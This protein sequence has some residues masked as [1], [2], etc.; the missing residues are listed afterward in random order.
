MSGNDTPTTGTDAKPPPSD[1]AGAA[2]DRIELRGLRL[3]AHVGVSEAE[4]MQAQP[5]ELDV[6]LLVD[7]RP[8]AESD[9]V[10]DTVDYG[11]AAIAIAEAVGHGQHH[12]LERVAKVAADAAFGA[13]QRVRA[14]TV[15]VRKVR[16]PVPVDIVT[17]GVT[18][19]FE[20]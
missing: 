19:H 12:L 11:V 2:D 3:T 15:T 7:L 6:D 5:L 18:I 17:T 10:V 16:P 1:A 14:A 4:R 13:D 8:P 20:R 9:D